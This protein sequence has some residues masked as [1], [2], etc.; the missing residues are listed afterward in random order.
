M[1]DTDDDGETAW[2]AR[3]ERVFALSPEYRRVLESGLPEIPGSAL[4]LDRSALP[5]YA[6]AT[7]A[8]TGIASALE[9]L[10]AAAHLWVS[11]GRNTAPRAF[12]TLLRPALVGAAQ[13]H[14]LLSPDDRNTRLM[15]ARLLTIETHKRERQFYEGLRELVPLAGNPG[16]A[17]LELESKVNSLSGRIKAVQSDL[18]DERDNSS[19]TAIVESLSKEIY[20]S[21]PEMRVGVLALW[22]RSSGDAHALPWTAQHREGWRERVQPPRSADPAD[23]RSVRDEATC[24]DVGQM[25]ATAHLLVD[26]ALT[27]YNSRRRKSS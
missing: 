26:E 6:T 17:G 18:P 16:E 14:W 5:V 9:H 23:T 20:E 8:W 22:R 7:L 10:V 13:A 12:Y 15:R 21:Q 1:A 4:A 2:R 11:L 27:L 19:V 24:S 3:I 25:V